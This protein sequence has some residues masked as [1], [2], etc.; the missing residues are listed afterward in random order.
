MP[1]SNNKG[2]LL[3]RRCNAREGRH[4]LL[5]LTSSTPLGPPPFSPLLLPPLL[6][7]RPGQIHFCQ[8]LWLRT[9]D[10]IFGCVI[11][12]CRPQHGVFCCV[13]KSIDQCYHGVLLW[14]SAVLIERPSPRPLAVE[15]LTSPTCG[16]RFWTLEQSTTPTVNHVSFIIS[17]QPPPP[18]PPPPPPQMIQR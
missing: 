7:H 6:M 9:I 18:C 8:G 15:N 1:S 16:N 4:S 2:P 13:E 3:Q 14:L 5:C 12:C 10:H 11:S 17:K